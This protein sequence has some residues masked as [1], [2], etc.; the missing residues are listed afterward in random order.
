MRLYNICVHFFWYLTLYLWFKFTSKQLYIHC[1]TDIADEKKLKF[2]IVKLLSAYLWGYYGY[3]FVNV[4]TSIN[5]IVAYKT[6]LGY[7][8]LEFILVVCLC[9]K[10]S[11]MH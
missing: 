5:G 9:L 10:F 1:K 2:E 8:Y 11:F 4:C 6:P 7:H 3:G